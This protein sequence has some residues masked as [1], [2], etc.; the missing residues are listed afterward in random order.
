MYFTCRPTWEY[1][2]VAVLGKPLN[3][4]NESHSLPSLRLSTEKNLIDDPATFKIEQIYSNGNAK[5][6]WSTLPAFDLFYL[7]DDL[8]RAINRAGC[9]NLVP[10][11]VLLDWNTYPAIQE[12]ILKL[13]RSNRDGPLVLKSAIGSGGKG[14]EFVNSEK[15]LLQIISQHSEKEKTEPTDKLTKQNNNSSWVLQQH[16]RSLLINGRKCHIRAYILVY[17][18][19]YLYKTMEVRVAESMYNN[20]EN[21]ANWKDRSAH[22]TNGGGRDKTKRYLISE[23][24]ELAG[25]ENNI[26]DFLIK[27]L[28]GLKDQIIFSILNEENKSGK[29]I[30]R[31]A[32]F[33]VDIMVDEDKRLWL[34]EFNRRPAVP[35]QEVL[36]KAFRNHLI[37]LTT[38][39]CNFVLEDMHDNF[40]DLGI[41][42]KC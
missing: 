12:E 16:I 42:I 19:I 23:I 17:D 38:S 31:Y 36:S 26:Q 7:K 30:E 6:A 20:T 5:Y 10:K 13:F 32:F 11:S 35:P 3:N 27:L 28:N 21:H 29:N 40:I 41:S 34:L 25:L 2:F 18:K 33:A 1:Y 9:S 37:E 22:I 8:V 24:S 4:S 14:I 15:E 39:L